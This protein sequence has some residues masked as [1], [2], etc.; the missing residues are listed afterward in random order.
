[1][2]HA[3]G[4]DIPESLEDLCTRS[5]TA[6]LVYDMQVGVVS[7][8]R[9][10][11]VIVE[12]IARLLRSTRTAGIR[13][14]Y[15][16]HYFMPNE[17]AGVSQLR[18]AKTWQRVQRAE[19]VKPR[20]LQGSPGF[21]VVDAL[22]P[23]AGRRPHR[24]DRHVRIRGNASARAPP[25]SGAGELSGR[26]NRAGDWHRADGPARRGPGFHPSGGPGCLRLRQR[27]GGATIARSHA[28]HGR[29]SVHRRG[30]ALRHP[31]CGGGARPDV[32]TARNGRRRSP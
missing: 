2:D 28:V 29:R 31:G 19:Q 21:Q 7:Q 24:Q 14:V 13:V 10:G 18:M 30:P 32:L 11:N 6:L 26:W 1:M 25:R 5:R 15:S 16:R 17:W 23:Q 20:L 9:G 12:R 27:R 22:A 4:L 3:F 8:V